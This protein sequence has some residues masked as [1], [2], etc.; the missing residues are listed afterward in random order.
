MSG[1]T[2]RGTCNRNMHASLTSE[3]RDERDI[4]A[5]FS[6]LAPRRPSARD[7]HGEGE[8]EGG[9]GGSRS[10]RPGDGGR[11][12][13]IHVL[14][15]MVS[16]SGC[17]LSLIVGR[18]ARCT[19]PASTLCLCVCRSC[20][21][22]LPR[23][24]ARQLFS[25][26]CLTECSRV[27][28]F[29]PGSPRGRPSLFPEHSFSVRSL[30]GLGKRD[31]SSLSL[32][33]RNEHN[34]RARSHTETEGNKREHAPHN[35]ERDEWL[36]CARRLVRPAAVL[37]C[38]QMRGE[39]AAAAAALG[40]FPCSGFT[41]QRPFLLTPSLPLDRECTHTSPVRVRD[42]DGNSCYQEG[43]ERGEPMGKESMFSVTG[44]PVTGAGIGCDGSAPDRQESVN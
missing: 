34:A 10:D 38:S 18:E 39:T 7:E 17:S 44:S 13:R 25:L 14:A 35:Q 20:S 19:V 28:F 29:C 5:N 27:F 6:A 4:T 36:H 31:P 30:I 26:T 32:L 24:R 23:R 16:Q 22:R 43:R 1:R 21:V 42:R 12:D 8:G 9:G 2:S 41:P 40:L 15:F 11:H 37:V 3:W 33:K